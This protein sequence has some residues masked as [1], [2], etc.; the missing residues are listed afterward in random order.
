MSGTWK[1]I[2][3][4]SQPCGFSSL[5]CAQCSFSS[6]MPHQECCF[7]SV[8]LCFSLQGLLSI[9]LLS[10]RMLSPDAVRTGWL[11]SACCTMIRAETP[12]CFLN[13]LLG[14]V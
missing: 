4:I 2:A 11:C 14:F 8:A 7:T 3:A 1:F 6:P 13:L 12:C 9:P 5:F 10:R